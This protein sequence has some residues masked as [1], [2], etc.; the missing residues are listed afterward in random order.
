MKQLF[1]YFF[2]GLL[3]IVP[4]TVTIYILFLV[5]GWLDNLIPIGVPGMGLLLILV[6]TTGLGYFANLFFIGSF[7]RLFETFVEKIPLVNIIYSSLRD[8]TSAFVGEKRRFDQAVL[9]SLSLDS[10][11]LKP[12]FVT[13]D[14]LAKIGLPGFVTVYMPHSYN[15]SGNI[16]IVN[17]KHV[18]PIEASGADVMRYIVSGGV[19]GAISVDKSHKSDDPS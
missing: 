1:N 14:D 5:I 12:G 13:S 2:K 10:T 8:L 18:I 16:I 15:F 9:V 19:S 3:I 7:F 6:V 17:S 11:I 4:L